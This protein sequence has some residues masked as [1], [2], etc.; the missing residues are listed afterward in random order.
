MEELGR[1]GELPLFPAVRIDDPLLAAE[2]RTLHAQLSN[3]QPPIA[4][5]TG[6]LRLLT[7]LITRYGSERLALPIIGAE[8]RAITEARAYLQANYAERVTLAA[9]AAHVGLSPFHLVRVFQRA[10][11][12]PPHTY[13]ESVRIRQAQRCIAEGMALGEVAYT[14]GFNSQSHFTTRFRR[15]IGVTPGAYRAGL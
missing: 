9:L 13:L 8:P 7:K 10:C 6:W 11:G 5:E 3:E 2:L 15:I 14:V 12:T 1:S 4:R